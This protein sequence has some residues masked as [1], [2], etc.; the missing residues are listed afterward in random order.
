MRLRA[1]TGWSLAAAVFLT[2]CVVSRAA[3]EPGYT[4]QE[5]V[6]YG[7]KAGMAL[8]MD[9]FTPKSGANGAGVIYVV[10]GGWVSNH[11]GIPGLTAR[12]F[13]PLL[14]RGY[15]IF[16]VVPG[17]Q[18][19]FTIPEIIHDVSRS[20]RFIRHHAA[21]YHVD[22][23]RLGIM[24]ASA[25]GHLSLI[26]GLAAPKPNPAITYQNPQNDPI[27]A[28]PATVKAVAAF[29]PPTDFLNYG[30]EGE[31]ALGRG[32]L[33]NFRTAFDFRKLDPAKKMLVSLTP[34]EEKALAPFISPITYASKD[35][36]ATLLI[37]GDADKLVPIQQ[38]EILEK[39]LKEVG[40]PVK[41]IVKPGA[42][43]GWA[44]YSL[45]LAAIG[46]W[47]DMYLKK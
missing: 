14:K 42:A 46:D 39:K 11:S 24:G 2:G 5:D 34:E 29:F 4:K 16:A 17:S 33:E 26:Q 15:T 36:P 40:T 35:D 44:D 18:P 19:T 9:V 37:H 30:K 47:F 31:N 1:V 28:E 8:T 6:I 3:D 13:E 21:K 41:L 7:R 12:M 27:D 10:S 43:H 22:A 32:I 38:S 20:V 23:N 45:D 25:G